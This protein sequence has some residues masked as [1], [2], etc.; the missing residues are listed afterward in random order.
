MAYR[1]PPL[2]PKQLRLTA[3]AE[4]DLD[5]IIRHIAREAD[6]EVAVRFAQRIDDELTKLA[7]I[8]HSGVSREWVSPGLR[9][10]TIGDY[11]VF[12]RLT[13]SETIIVRVLHGHRDIDAIIFEPPKP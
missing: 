10:T 1:P 12:F 11:C 3:G 6:R 13:P 4:A 7:H 5:D 2:G 8:G 9:L